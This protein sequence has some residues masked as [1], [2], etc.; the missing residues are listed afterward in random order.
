MSESTNEVEAEVRALKSILTA[1]SS[2]DESTRKRVLAYASQRFGLEAT[3]PSS[4][5]QP[6]VAAT[7]PAVPT[8]G[9]Q[10]P[11]TV[12][13]DIRT[14]KDQKKP[15]SAIEMTVLVAYYLREAAPEGEK[16][17]AIGSTEIDKYFK[18]ADYPLPGRARN[19][20]FQ[21]KNAGYLDSEKQGQYTL[22]P[23]GYNLVAHGMPRA[24]EKGTTRTVSRKKSSSKHKTAS[25]RKKAQTA[26]KRATT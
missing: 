4:S 22:N 9:E 11:H 2:L 16:K 25:S 24:K 6:L 17:A 7:E 1:L 26:R 23:V 18:Q 13:T 5:S 21:A 14:L 15:R 20:L 19:V 12:V 3:P 8:D 10:A